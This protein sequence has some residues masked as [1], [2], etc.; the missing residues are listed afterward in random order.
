MIA[1]LLRT[2]YYKDGWVDRPLYSHHNAGEGAGAVWGDI[3]G[4]REGGG[5]VGITQ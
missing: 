5:G 2:L 4:S 1:R 3:E